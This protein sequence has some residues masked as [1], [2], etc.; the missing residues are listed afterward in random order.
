[1]PVLGHYFSLSSF[2]GYYFNSGTA[3]L[4]LSPSQ[5][6][7]LAPGPAWALCQLLLEL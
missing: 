7:P 6:V 2:S 5:A 4:G 3:A 1:M